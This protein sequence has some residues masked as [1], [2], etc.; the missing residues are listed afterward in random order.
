MKRLTAILICILLLT[1]GCTQELRQ[2]TEFNVVASFYPVYIFTL[3]V[4]KGA[5]DV[6]VSVMA[7][8]EIGCLH[9][10]QL[11]PVDMQ[12]LEDA[13]AFIIN[14]A[15]MESFISDVAAEL[16]QLSVVDFVRRN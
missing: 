6:T 11:M 3:N 15:G 16:P 5:K 2:N 8:N 13:E 9:D 12:R 14:G 10:Y 1:S 7:G 4:T